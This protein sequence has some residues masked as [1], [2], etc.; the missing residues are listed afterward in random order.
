MPYV[1][2]C[3]QS[4]TKKRPDF[5]KCFHCDIRNMCTHV[6][7]NVLKVYILFSVWYTGGI[8]HENNMEDI[9]TYIIVYIY[10]IY[11]K[12]N[13]TRNFTRLVVFGLGVILKPKTTSRALCACMRVVL[14]KK[15]PRF[16]E[17]ISL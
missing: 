15:T 2:A 4:F 5:W 14:Y 10:Y 9:Y 1:H 13:L 16:L 17:M 12:S 8:L 3:G 11:Y 7:N 6:V